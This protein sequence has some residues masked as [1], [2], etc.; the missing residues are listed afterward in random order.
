MGEVTLTFEPALA[1]LEE[2]LADLRLV[3]LLADLTQLRELDQLA[4][5]DVALLVGSRGRRRALEIIHAVGEV[6]VVSVGT[7]A[8]HEKI[9]AELSLPAGIARLGVPAPS[10]PRGLDVRYPVGEGAAVALGAHPLLEELAQDRL[11]LDSR[12]RR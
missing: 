12:R 2:V 8:V 7:D 10:G 5:V 4:E 1:R 6:T 3:V 9:S 11:L